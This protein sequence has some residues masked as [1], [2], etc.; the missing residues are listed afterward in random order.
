MNPTDAVTAWQRYVADGGIMMFGLVPTA[1]LMV[2]YVVQ[3]LINLRRARVCPRGFAERMG[4]LAASNPNRKA[5]IASLESEGTSV[6]LVVGRVLRHLEFKPDADPVA[7]LEDCIVEESDSLQRR[8][9]HLAA[10]YTVAPLMGL[11][12]TVLGMLQ[13]FNEFALSENPTVT[14][15]SKG[16]NVAF[17]TTA[18][19]LGIAVPCIIFLQFFA[20][21]IS[22]YEQTILPK[23]GMKALETV[24]PHDG[25]AATEKT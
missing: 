1:L 19:G 21:R 6:A 25:L 24:L 14:E 12:G 4:R 17:I 11:L 7:I 8:N 13:T 9:N 16:I 5:L 20:R 3:G 10:L 22:N 2:A 15:L 23:E 18:W